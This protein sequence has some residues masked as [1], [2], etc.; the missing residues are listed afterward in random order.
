MISLVNSMK[1]LKKS[2]YPSDTL[3]KTAEDGTLPSSF[4]EATLTLIPQ[5]RKLQVNT[6]DK[7]RCQ[8]AQQNTNKLNPQKINRIIHI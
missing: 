8:N 7:H 6:M 1:H 4:Y 3:P 2:T 5:K